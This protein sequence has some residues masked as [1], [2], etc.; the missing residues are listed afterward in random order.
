[1]PDTTR[2]LVRTTALV[3]VL[4]GALAVVHMTGPPAYLLWELL[5]VVALVTTVWRRV[6]AQPVEEATPRPLW[7][8]RRTRPP[9]SLLS[10]ELEVAGAGDP[11]LGDE[12]R[13]RR[14]L[15]ALAAHRGGMEVG[16]VGG[17]SGRRLLG[18]EAARVLSGSGP[19]TPGEVE[20]LIDRVSRL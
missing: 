16:E 18:E 8:R 4:A 14:R 13:L 10:L 7:T 12:M 9:A 1:M 15:T 19:I 2:S 20:M 6:P 11:R 5:L 17:E 3:A